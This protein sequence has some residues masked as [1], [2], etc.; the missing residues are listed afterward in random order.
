MKC[1][2]EE[3][4]L[5]YRTSTSCFAKLQHLGQNYMSLRNI[6]ITLWKTFKSLENIS[7]PWKIT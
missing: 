3:E 1:S 6:L 2:F 4:L 5:P 7:K